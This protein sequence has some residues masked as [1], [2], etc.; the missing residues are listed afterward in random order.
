VC[1]AGNV[2]AVLPAFMSNNGK[3]SFCVAMVEALK[4][5]QQLYAQVRYC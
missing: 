3:N 5:E 2:L 1:A 4:A